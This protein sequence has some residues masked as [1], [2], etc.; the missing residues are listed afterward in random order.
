MFTERHW[1]CLFRRADSLLHDQGHCMPDASWCCYACYKA[2]AHNSRWRDNLPLH[3]TTIAFRS[4]IN[5]VKLDW[6][7]YKSVFHLVKAAGLTALK[8]DGVGSW[9]TVLLP[10]GTAF[11][12]P[13]LPPDTL[14]LLT[15][16]LKG[17][18]AMGMMHTKAW[19]W[20]RKKQLAK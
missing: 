8:A 1:F 14:N 15:L 2:A 13:E 11:P 4:S 9:T 18:M 10:S 6:N 5:S 17:N 19:E 16:P 7:H 3:H 20:M 12:M